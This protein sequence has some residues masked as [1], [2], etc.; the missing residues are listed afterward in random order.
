MTAKEWL[1][2][3]AGTRV[4]LKDT[5]D[6]YDAQSAWAQAVSPGDIG[7][8]VNMQTFKDRAERWV[9]FKDKGATIRL[10]E[11]SVNLA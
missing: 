11:R 7:W 1:S 2:V 4:V 8:V 5:L 3:P 10:C 9:C 6:F